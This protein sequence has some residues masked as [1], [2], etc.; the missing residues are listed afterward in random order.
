MLRDHIL[1]FEAKQVIDAEFR[2][3]G[4]PVSTG[5]HRSSLAALKT[6][7]GHLLSGRIAAFGNGPEHLVCPG[8]HPL[9]RIA[10]RVFRQQRQVGRTIE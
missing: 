3:I 7:F 1:G 9:Q 8:Q 2:E 10:Q 5:Q 4:A 6:W